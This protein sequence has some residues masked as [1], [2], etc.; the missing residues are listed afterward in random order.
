M[1][2]EVLPPKPGTTEC[3]WCAKHFPRSDRAPTKTADY[4]SEHHA[5]LHTLALLRR[6]VK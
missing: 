4:C 2:L 1:H 6:G 5:N 3:A